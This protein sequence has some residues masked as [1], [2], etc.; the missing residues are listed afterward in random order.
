MSF[1][2]GEMRRKICPKDKMREIKRKIKRRMELSIGGG[3][4][5]RVD[6]PCPAGRRHTNTTADHTI[7]S[8]FTSQSLGGDG[9]HSGSPPKVTVGW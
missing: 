6:I 2:L 1:V 9:T 4:K 5:R 3:R 8:A 7:E